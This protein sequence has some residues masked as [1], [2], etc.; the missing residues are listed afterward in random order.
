MNYSSQVLIVDDMPAMRAIIMAAM[1]DLGF[2]SF[3]ECED[4]ESAWSVLQEDE[5]L[6]QIGLV[7]ADW[8]MGGMSGVDLL[9]AVRGCERK[10]HLP[11]IMVTAQ[12][13]FTNID[14]A[15][16]NLADGYFVK[17]F[18]IN[19]LKERVIRMMDPKAAPIPH[20]SP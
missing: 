12:R 8:K 11:F 1:Q 9:R 3:I 5:N 7:V 16:Q 10:R 4:G 6:D 17:P 15:I 20:Q 14:E 18:D 2:T 19:E 13:D